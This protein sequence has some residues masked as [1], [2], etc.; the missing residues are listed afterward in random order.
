MK[1]SKLLLLLLISTFFSATAKAQLSREPELC[2]VFGSSFA[3]IPIPPELCD[4]PGIEL[5]QFSLNSTYDYM[6]ETTGVAADF[7]LHSVT[8]SIVQDYDLLE[9]EQII[10]IIEVSSDNLAVGVPDPAHTIYSLNITKAPGS[11]NNQVCLPGVVCPPPELSYKLFVQWGDISEGT[12]NAASYITLDNATDYQLVI[13][14]EQH[15]NNGVG[16]V[17]LRE[18][19]DITA[20]NQETL[21]TEQIRSYN[22]DNG[23]DFARTYYHGNVDTNF[24]NSNLQGVI[25]IQHVRV[26]E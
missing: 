2:D 11:Q 14:W 16:S 24:D 22:N 3:N 19:V 21:E 8:L 1:P 6:W 26:P 17:D 10:R 18:F 23:T 20:I 9:A 13:H 12:S 15:G 25:N 4:R 5:M 7:I